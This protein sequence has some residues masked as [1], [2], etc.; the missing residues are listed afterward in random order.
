[1]KPENVAILYIPLVDDLVQKENNWQHDRVIYFSII[2]H[3]NDVSLAY[4]VIDV[5]PVFSKGNPI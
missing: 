3:Y 2:V 1:M 4:P 5:L